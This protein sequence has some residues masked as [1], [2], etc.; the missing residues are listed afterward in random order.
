MSA[1]DKLILMANQIARNLEALGEAE[2]IGATAEH[3]R[4]YWAPQM[5][6]AMKTH[7]EREE[8]R[9]LSAIALQ[10]LQDVVAPEGTRRDG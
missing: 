10:A 8:G 3:I 4:K 5:R 7:I 9:G 1:A 6:A 2:A